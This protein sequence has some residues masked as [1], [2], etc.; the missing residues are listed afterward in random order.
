MYI[1]VEPKQLKAAVS[2]L[3]SA[4]GS[5]T[6]QPI[7][8]QMLLEAEASR[9]IART[10]N[11]EMSVRYRLAA[12]VQ[13][14]GVAL[15]PASFFASLVQDLPPA[16]LT[17]A[18]PGPTDVTAAQL[19]CRNVQAHVKLA[20]LP[21]EEFPSYPEPGQ[22]L[23]TI[24]GELLRE[25][26]EQVAYAAATHDSSRPVMEGISL[27][28]EGGQASFAAADAFRL[29]L[30]RLAIPDPHLRA[31]LILP[32]HALRALARLLP[33][34]DAVQIT[35]AASGNQ[36]LFQ[37]PQLDAALRLIAGAFPA[38]GPLLASPSSTRVVVPTHV[39]AEALRLTA[40]V[41]RG[42]GHQLVLRISPAQPGEAAAL[43]LEAQAPDLGTTSIRLE[44]EVSVEGVGLTLLVQDSFLA[45]ALAVV[46]ARSVLLELSDARHP[47]VIKPVGPLEQVSIIMPLAVPPPALAQAQQAS[48]DVG[49]AAA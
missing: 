44:E 35:L 15:L 41:A 14:T 43:V 8:Q 42:N 48:A 2:A 38:Y 25:V 11:E 6:Q 49:V 24:D 17:M 22:P 29:A 47:I 4:S 9:I 12:R 19:R 21:I 18:V 28:V 33:T 39:L 13:A 45:E 7:L 23:L 27:S 5:K 40:P 10:A 20:M 34:G 36:V 31:N 3:Q 37:T 1:T 46:S 26:I 30:R 32:A 16:P